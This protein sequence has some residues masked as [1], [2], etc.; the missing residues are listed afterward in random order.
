MTSWNAIDEAIGRHLEGSLEELG[1]LCAVPSVSAQGTAMRECAELLVNMLQ[2]RGFESRIIATDGHPIVYAERSGRSDRTVLLY[3][4]Y[5]VQPAEPLDLW[6][7]PSFDPSRRDGQLFARG[8]SDDNGHIECR[9]AAL[10]SF[11]HV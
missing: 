8:V 3:N 4:H 1:R 2:A 5:D 9:L 11:L 10:D 7:S 6:E